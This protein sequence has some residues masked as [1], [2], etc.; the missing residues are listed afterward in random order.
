VIHIQSPTRVDLAGG[1]LDCWPLYLF[2]GDCV[3]VNLAIDIYTGCE[4]K[5][6][7]D[8][9][10]DFSVDIEIVDLNYK[11]SFADLGAVLISPD[12]ELLLLQKIFDYFQ[13]RYGFFLKT[14][15]QS[16]V[17]GGLGGSSSLCVSLIRAFNEKENIQQTPVEL[18]HLAHNLEA[19][20][21]H[22]PTGTQDYYPALLGG[23][24]VM[25]YRAGGITTEL[26]PFSIDVFKK[27]MM[28]IHTGKA[29]HSGINNWQVIKSVVEKNQETISC[30][31]EIARIADDTARVCRQGEWQMLPE[32]F[33]REFEARIR[34][35]PSF[36]S[37]EIETLKKIVFA[38]GGSAVKICGAGGGG[39]VL[40]WADHSLHER[41]SEACRRSGFQTIKAYPVLPKS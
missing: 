21:L 14:Y 31:K 9:S 34:L 25:H 10:S 37:P 15:S 20:V 33:K 18:V 16:P 40:V 7:S 30:L 35:A 32:L 8:A 13:P 27:N 39:T 3:T 23:L 26:I 11:K 29:H 6:R 41:I 12:R 22:A 19:Q 38:A 4:L 1:T 28:L 36:T 2:V 17:G 24:N 5:T